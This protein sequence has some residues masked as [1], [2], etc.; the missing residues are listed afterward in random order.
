MRQINH[1][2]LALN[3]HQAQLLPYYTKEQDRRLSSIPVNLLAYPPL[4]LQQVLLS[5]HLFPWRIAKP[6][7]SLPL[8]D[9]ILLSRPEHKPINL[10][11]NGLRQL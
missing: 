11:S 1:T 8:P 9:S 4:S 7:L 2:S 6:N 5:P 3:R 10:N